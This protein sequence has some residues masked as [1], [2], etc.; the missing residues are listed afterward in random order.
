MQPSE[1]VHIQPRRRG[2]DRSPLSFPS[3]IMASRRLLAASCACGVN[4]GSLPSG[5]STISEVRLLSLPHSHQN[6]L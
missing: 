1:T 4:G 6:S 3:T 5:G 2:R